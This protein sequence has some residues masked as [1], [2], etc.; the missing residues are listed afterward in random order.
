M[1]A[2]VLV[3]VQEEAP[4]LEATFAFASVARV[5]NSRTARN[6][7][8]QRQAILPD[9]TWALELEMQPKRQVQVLAMAQG[10]DMAPLVPVMDM[11]RASLAVVHMVD[12]WP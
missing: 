10:M 9:Q 12:T 6:L 4:F 3:L 5:A 2:L 1:L 11:V 8:Y 7:A